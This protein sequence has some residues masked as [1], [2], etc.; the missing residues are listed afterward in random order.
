M[1]ELSNYDKA[2][3]DLQQADVEGSHCIPVEYLRAVLRKYDI[4]SSDLLLKRFLVGPGEVCNLHAF[5]GGA[6]TVA[7][8]WRNP[9]PLIAIVVRVGQWVQ[10]DYVSLLNAVQELDI[11]SVVDPYEMRSQTP[12]SFASSR[13]QTARSAYALPLGVMMVM[14]QS[15]CVYACLLT[16][17]GCCLLVQWCIN[18][19]D[20]P[21]RP[22][23]AD[24]DPSNPKAD[25]EA[26]LQKKLAKLQSALEAADTDRVLP[27]ILREHSRW[28][29]ILMRFCL[30]GVTLV[31]FL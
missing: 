9:L 5:S 7:H 27:L 24:T 26:R 22:F 25:L 14:R 23:A 15:V 8:R 19:Y 29:V 12:R 4:P 11:V 3:R 21:K 2:Y 28:K 6:M 31:W 30:S 13:P 1:V 18:S 10:V 16:S 17:L 20:G